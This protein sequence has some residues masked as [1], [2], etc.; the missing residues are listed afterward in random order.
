MLEFRQPVFQPGLQI[1][2]V[3]ELGIRQPRA[4]HALVAGDDRLAAVGRLHVGNQNEARRERAIAL[5][6]HE[7]FLVVADG[8]ADHF[9]R[10]R[11]EV[12]LERAHQHHRPFDQ[13]ADLD[14]QAVVLDQ[15]VALREGKVLR[16]GRDDLP[17]PLRIDD[18]LGLFQLRHPVVLAAHRDRA[19]RQE[20][21]A[22]GDVAGFQAVDIEWHDLRVFGLRAEGRDDRMQRTHPGQRAGLRRCR[23]PAHRFR[24]GKFADDVGHDLGDHLDRGAAGL[25]DHRDIELALLRVLLDLRLIERGRAPRS[26]ESPRPRPPARRRA[27]PSSPRGYPSAW[28]ECRA[29]RARSGAASRTP[30]RLHRRGRPRPAGR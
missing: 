20:A 18:D 11:E 5:L 1:G 3:E 15:F 16:L 30:W 19:R 14:Q 21:M 17:P 13:A 29:R 6:H 9:R 28:P 24:P 7:A 8:G 10:D 23:P 22:E 27:V 25:L 4:D 2:L 26:S 12:L